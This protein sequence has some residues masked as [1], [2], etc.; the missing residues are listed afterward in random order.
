LGQA[1][2]YFER[3][4]ERVP[5]Y[6][7]AYQQHSDLYIHLLMNGATG[8]GEG[9]SEAGEVNEAMARAR[10]DYVA[11]VRY[12]RSPEERNNAEWDLAFVTGDWQGM[13][14]RIERFVGERGCHEPNWYAELVFPFGYAQKLISRTQ[15]FA[16]CDPLSSSTWRGAVRAQLFGGDPE[17]ALQT[18]RRGTD[19]APGEWLSLELISALVA[20]GKFDEASTVVAERLRVETD[21]LTGRIMIAAAQGDRVLV[22]ELLEQFR[23]DRPQDDF[24]GDSY[25]AWAGDRDEANRRAARVDQYSFGSPALVTM[26]LWCR[27]AAFRGRHRRIRI[28][29]AAGLAD[30]FSSEELVSNFC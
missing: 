22:G 21:K 7:Y 10:A 13:P 3:V 17:G 8:E 6:S 26:L 24:W 9:V 20:L 4:L 15:E 30:S 23:K 27:C 28:A 16:V 5:G 11:V 25:Y 12:A 19:K 18:A 2:A 14:A 29:L 1:N